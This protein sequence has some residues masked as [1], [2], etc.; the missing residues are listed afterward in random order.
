VLS[1]ARFPFHLHAILRT[2]CIV[3]SRTNILPLAQ[4]SGPARSPRI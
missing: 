3:G 1:L 2:P 4:L